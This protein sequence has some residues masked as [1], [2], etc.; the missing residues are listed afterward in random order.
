M[1]RFVLNQFLR[2]GYIYEEVLYPTDRGT[3]Q[4]GI[5]SPILANMTLDGME[6]SLAKRF[7]KGNVYFIR[8]ADD[9]LVTT[10]TKERAEE[11]RETIRNSS[12]KEALN[13]LRRRR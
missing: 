7:P 8:Y 3:P 5:I 11:A 12:L 9:F 10:P 4:G 13:S 6:R 2:A 1:D